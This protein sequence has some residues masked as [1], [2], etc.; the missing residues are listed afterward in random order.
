[1]SVGWKAL[2]AQERQVWALHQHLV[3]VSLQRI[4]SAQVY[5]DKAKKQKEQY[6]LYLAGLKVPVP[7]LQTPLTCTI[8]IVT[9]APPPPPPCLAFLSATPSDLPT[10]YSFYSVPKPSMHPSASNNPSGSSEGQPS[11]VAQRSWTIIH[12][13]RL[14][15]D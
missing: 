1:M 13:C 5:T 6:T 4:S 7:A 8:G 2:S 11:R 3:Q 9:N 12:S 10:K 14:V 15:R